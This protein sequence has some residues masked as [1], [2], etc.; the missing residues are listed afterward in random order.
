MDKLRVMLV[1][2]HAVVR[3]GFKVLLQTWD[4]VQVVAEADSGEEALRIYDGVAPDLVVMDIAMAG[5]GGIEA[6]KRL[7]ARDPQVR[8]LA[9]SAHE[10]TSYS[11]RAFQAGA[12]G[13]LSKRT[14]P[15]VLVDAIRLVAQGKRFIDPGIAQRMAMQ[16]L[17]GET[18]PLALLSPREFEVFMQIA[19]GQ[20]VVAV[21]ETLNLSVSTVGTHVHKIKQKLDLANASE[22][23]LLA[24]RQGLIDASGLGA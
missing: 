17:S 13:Y 21:A 23:T 14:A 6:I 8:V 24:L 19:R 16:D 18:D 2:D 1:D 7:V 5:M 11:K 4:D 20:S 15:E 22:I 12:L 10:D 3:G 9:L